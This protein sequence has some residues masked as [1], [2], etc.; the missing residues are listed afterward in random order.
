MRQF[1]GRIALVVSDYD[2]AVTF[3]T[4]KLHF[5]LV[6]DT[7]LP[8]TKRWVVLAPPGSPKDGCCISLAKATDDEQRS[9]I[10]SLFRPIWKFVGPDRTGGVSNSY[11]ADRIFM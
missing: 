6:E 2:E 11:S 3:Y 8:I 5:T 10:G 1:L 9:C 7:V 4:R